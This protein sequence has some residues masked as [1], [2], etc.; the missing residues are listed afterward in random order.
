MSI[1]PSCQPA[2]V[3]YGEQPNLIAKSFDTLLTGIRSRGAWLRIGT[4]YLL[5]AVSWSVALVAAVFIRYDFDLTPVRWSSFAIVTLATVVVQFPVG[6]LTNLYRSRHPY[7]SFDEALALVFTTFATAV[8]VGVPVLVWGGTLEFPR[9]AVAIAFPLAVVL[10]GGI[11]YTTRL[12]SDRAV[13]PAEGTQATLVYG[14]GYLGSTIVR[15][16]LTDGQSAYR[17]V[18]LIDDSPLRRRSWIDGVR[19]LGTGADLAK[20]AQDTGATVLVVAI[21]RA[22]ASLLRKISDEARSSYL[23]VKVLPPLEELLEGKS[24]LRDLRNIN[25]EDLIGRHPVDTGIEAIA[26]YLKNKRVLVTGAGGSIGSEL[27]RQIS[28]FDPA[29][30]MLLDHD[31]TSLQATQISIRGHGLLDSTDVILASIRDEAALLS[32]FKDRRPEVV[33]HAAALKHLP[34]LEQYPDEAWKSNVL[35]TWNVL[36]AAQAVDVATFVNIS[37]DKAAN[38]TSVL[39]HSKRVAERITAWTG[40]QSGMRYLSVRFG[41]VLGSRG[42]VLPT[43]DA[44]IQRGGPVTITH[45]DVTRFFMTIPEACQLLIQAGGIGEPGEVLILDMG[46]PVKIVDLAQRMIDLSGQDIAIVYTGLRPGEKL[47]EELIGSGESDSRPVHDKISHT[48]VPVMSP[49]MLNRERWLEGW[50][51]STA[52]ASLGSDRGT[53]E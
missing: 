10:M 21:A 47:H 22:D 24:R 25:I 5:D 27:C 3:V 18:G 52:T 12:L 46:E 9:G 39:G 2:H 19:V 1:L 43:I 49:E 26:G 34:M 33:F 38:P 31:E 41:N 48:R 29:E 37:T 42:S 35:G 40:E 23:T 13:R 30:L 16:M 4:R 50:K 8:L 28:K 53:A 14:A 36:K 7:G 45:P 32:I 11:R 15:R 6:W 17:P 44:L 20:I 51:E